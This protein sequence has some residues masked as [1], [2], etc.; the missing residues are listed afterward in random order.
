[1][2]T[3]SPTPERR[4]F[5]QTSL[6]LLAFAI[7]LT[8]LMAFSSQSKAAPATIKFDNGRISIGS[9]FG[10]RVI[11]PATDTF[12]SPDL[13]TPQRTD[14]ELNADLTGDQITVPAATNT[15]LQFPYMNLLHP[16]GSGVKIPLTMR[17]NEPGLTGT[18][19]EATGAMT[20]EGEV[21][22]IVVTGTGT[23]FPVPDS[24]TDVGVPPLGL[25]ARCRVDNL[26]LSLSTENKKPITAERFTGGFG[27]DGALTASFDSLPAAKSEN[28][29]DC[30]LLNM[31]LD[32]PGGLWL[33]NGVVEPKPQPKP[34]PTCQTDF[35]LCPEP[36]FIEIDD[37]RLRPGRKAVRPGQK[38]VFT[39]R[40]HNSGNIPARNLKVKIKTT[41]KAFKV[42]KTVKLTVPARRS[43]KKKFVVRVKRNAKG[44]ARITA[45]K[46]GWAGNSFLRVKRKK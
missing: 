34:K 21:D 3:T 13:P 5:R 39:V 37:V 16:D 20:L 40:V 29:G 35:T 41:N 2:R 14:I 17:L 42:P 24:L 28:G 4:V 44:R 18:W 27:V 31:L 33:A 11:L 46:N 6:L 19:D 7:A 26:P 23:T 10:N 25:F 9:V 38:V 32:N 15:G 12:P 22:I 8:G 45:V 36:K 43:A 30:G 1:M